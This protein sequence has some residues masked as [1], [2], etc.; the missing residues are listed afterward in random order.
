MKIG[1]KY[2]EQFDCIVS[3]SGPLDLSPIR[4]MVP[5]VLQENG[6]SAPYEFNVEDGNLTYNAFTLAAAFSPNPEKESGVDFFIDENGELDEGVFQRW[7]EHNPPQFIE[8]FANSG[9][10]TSIYFDVGVKDENGLLA[11][12]DNFADSLDAFGVPYRYETFDGKHIDKLEER[13]EVSLAFIDSVFQ[14]I[15]PVGIETEPE[16]DR[17]V[18]EMFTLS[19]NYPNPFNP[20]TMIRFQLPVSSY[21]SLKVYDLLGREVAN[22]VDERES[23]GSH[24]VR[25]D[26][27]GLASGIYIYRLSTGDQAITRKMILMK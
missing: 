27:S 7:M 19:Q 20:S 2:P 14:S 17:D 21:V 5:L 12:N 1:L 4:N 26:A 11:F 3:H 13:Y 24:S 6:G 10:H 25:F 16:M 22:L 23:S 15:S 8:G 9:V 18:V